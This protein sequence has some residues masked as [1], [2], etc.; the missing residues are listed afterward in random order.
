MSMVTCFSNE[1][2]LPLNEFHSE[3]SRA[4]T[5]SVAGPSLIPLSL[6][7]SSAIRFS[8]VGCAKSSEASVVSAPPAVSVA[9]TDRSPVPSSVTTISSGVERPITSTVGSTWTRG[10]SDS[11]RG[12]KYQAAPPRAA[13]TTRKRMRSSG[14]ARRGR[15]VLKELI[16]CGIG[17]W[18]E[19]RGAILTCGAPRVSVGARRHCN[20]STRSDILLKRSGRRMAG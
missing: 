18:R 10:G 4:L 20:N 14:K 17:C 2:S 13:M 9:R 12:L 3:A 11:K 6:A 16:R 5:L 15:S 19:M 1:T 7:G 8:R